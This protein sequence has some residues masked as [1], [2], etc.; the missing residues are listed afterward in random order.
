MVAQK[1]HGRLSRCKTAIQYL[2]SATL[3]DS[4]L[5]HKE[6]PKPPSGGFLFGHYTSENLIIGI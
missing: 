5:G 3:V 2:A 1:V 4:C 6:A